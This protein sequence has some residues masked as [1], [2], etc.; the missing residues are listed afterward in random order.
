M[1]LSAL[2]IVAKHLYLVV[3]NNLKIV[4]MKT[5]YNIA[6]Y[7]GFSIFSTLFCY[8][9]EAPGVIAVESGIFVYGGGELPKNGYYLFERKAKKDRKYKE[10]AKTRVPEKEVEVEKK[11]AEIATH[12]K[13]LIYLNKK[14]VKRVYEY[15]QNNKTDDSL[16]R[17]EHTPII[18]IT[19]GTAFLDINVEKDKTYNYRVTLIKDGNEVFKK[20][21]KPLQNTV[22][23]NLPIPK[24]Y[25][26]DIV[27]DAVFLEWTVENQKDMTLFNVYRAYFGTLDFK[28]INIKKGYANNENGLNLI[29]IDDTSE[30][31]SLYKYYIQPVDLYGNV[32]VASDVISTGKL[33]A[34]SIVPI[35]SLYAEELNDYK[36]KLSWKLD[37]S[38]IR[39][40][41]QVWRSSNYDNGFIKVM[42]LPPA[43]KEF[44]DDLPKAS[45]NYYY[46]LVIHGG[47]RQ[48]FKSAK[49]A[50]MVKTNNEA[51][52]A[53][54]YIS[55]KPIIDGCEITW[56]HDEPYTRGFY[57]YRASDNTQKFNQISNLILANDSNLYAY[58]DLDKSLQ[59]GELYQYTVRAENDAYILGKSSDT[60][61]I[62]PGKKLKILKPQKL[63]TIYRDSIIEL[64]WDDMTEHSD[65]ILG[66]KVYRS[67]GENSPL[68]VMSNDSLKAYKNYFNDKDIDK[69][70]SYMYQVS[71][72]DMFGQESELSL[73]S[74]IT[75]PK[76]SKR[77]IIPNKPR[78]YKNFSGIT[79]SWNQIASQDI[80]EIKIY[81]SENSKQT[82]VIKNVSIREDK[83]I[84]TSAKKDILYYY[85]ISFITKD[86]R[87]SN[88]SRASSIYY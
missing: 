5:V 3:G 31:S 78:V 10:I 83:Y 74:V 26:S 72:L 76:N 43:T 16:Y 30:K 38:A 9:Q 4:K 36:I 11:A 2:E 67:E 66:Y 23:T 44:I 27:N 88:I 20:E 70:Q 58:K 73:A 33:Q 63:K 12:F 68:Q 46:Y 84:D 75:I 87:E 14:D 42:N 21:L 35:S 85:K 53:P 22:K 13:H 69:G 59:A 37:K 15:I 49:I 60:T 32:G 77:A 47:A 79:I 28:K 54:N 17:A 24:K 7:V 51:L 6:I 39:S 55:G 65:N 19:A 40:N 8:A 1:F 57:V 62:I 34:E 25:S 45:E 50:T 41:I 64:Y 61:H 71:T 86:G 82:K 81:R 48:E 56:Q 29:A 18:A 52:P 80:S